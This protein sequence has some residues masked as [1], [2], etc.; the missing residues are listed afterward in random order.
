M[1]RTYLP[2]SPSYSQ[3]QTLIAVELTLP[4]LYPY[5]TR[6]GFHSPSPPPA[7]HKHLQLL[8]LDRRSF[9]DADSPICPYRDVHPLTGEIP[10]SAGPNHS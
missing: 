5:T 10:Q 1:S 2:F 6:N 9:K 8:V 3:F 4:L 7:A